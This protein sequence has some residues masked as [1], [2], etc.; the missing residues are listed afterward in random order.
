[1]TLQV[2]SARIAYAGPDRFDVSR[3]SG[4][5]TDGWPF[6]PSWNILA[7]ALRASAI[8]KKLEK[9]AIEHET[10]VAI[11]RPDLAGAVGKTGRAEA[12]RVRRAAFDEYRPK[13][14]AEMRQSYRRN[15]FAWDHLLS[16]P[17]VV[18][19]C[20]CTRPELCHRAILR[21]EILPKLGAID[22][23]EIALFTSSDEAEAR[24]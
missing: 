8:A 16:R 15:R 12:D 3:Q 22:M 6:A 13:Y 7:P 17:R 2:F 10:V 9:K 11:H 14:L 23:G 5:K 24:R 4:S 18:C 21:A 19:V 20:Y 1:M